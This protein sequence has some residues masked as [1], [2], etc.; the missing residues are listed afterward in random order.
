[1]DVELGSE[2]LWRFRC[3]LTSKRVTAHSRSRA[4]ASLAS[5]VISATEDETSE[6]I[7]QSF[8]TLA[9]VY[10]AIAFY[11]EN[12]RPIND[13]MAE[14]QREFERSVPPLSQTNPELFAR[15]KAARGQIGSRRT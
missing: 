11:L 14:V 10:G 2:S 12:E 15:L 1:V 13:D 8:P 9:Q 6:K 3:H 7:V 5:I 4:R